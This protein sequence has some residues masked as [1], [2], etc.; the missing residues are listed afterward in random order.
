MKKS[1]LL[2]AIVVALSTLMPAQAERHTVIF[3]YAR[4]QLDNFSD[5]DGINIKYRYEWGSA[6]SLMNS[7][8]ALGGD[9]HSANG[10]KTELNYYAYSVGPA[11]YLNRYMVIYGL[12][13]LSHSNVKNSAAW[14]TEQN[15]G[16]ARGSRGA[17]SASAFAYGAGL[18]FT[19]RENIV[20]DV[21]YEG[22]QIDIGGLNRDVNLFTVGVGYRF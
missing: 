1:A 11:Y 21:G 14:A 12:V 13:G 9:N 7:F 19:P 2:G 5:L 17:S 16:R 3:D 22:S 18:L 8:S 20:L 6:L 15:S 4:A 10:G